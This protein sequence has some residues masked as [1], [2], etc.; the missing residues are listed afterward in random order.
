MQ[1]KILEQ[2]Q[3]QNDHMTKEHLYSVSQYIMLMH[4]VYTYNLTIHSFG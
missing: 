1:P 4:V 2:L 3:E